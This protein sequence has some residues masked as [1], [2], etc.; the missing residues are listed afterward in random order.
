MIFPNN[1]ISI[2]PK[3]PTN[4]NS[5]T[6]NIKGTDFK[7]PVDPRED[8]IIPYEAGIGEL[9]SSILVL[10]DTAVIGGGEHILFLDNK[11]GMLSQ[12]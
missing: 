10:Y 5:M 3:G 7:Y 8:R 1:I 2:Y 12:S 4:H 9:T 6:C 11:Q